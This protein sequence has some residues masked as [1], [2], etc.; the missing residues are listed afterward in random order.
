MSFPKEARIGLLVSITIV[1][2]FLGFFFLKGAD[3][4]SGENTYYSYFNNVQ[5]LQAS[6]PV[7]V[8]GLTVGRVSAINLD[9]N[10]RVRVTMRIG[11]ST[12]VPVGSIAKLSS[13]DLL[14]TKAIALVLGTGNSLVTDESVLPSAIEGGLVDAL[15]AQIT[16]LLVDVR[17]A[18]GTLDSLLVGVNGVLD[19]EA[20]QHLRASLASLNTTMDNF[21]RV[22]TRL[23]AESDELAGIIRNT[24]NI[25][26]NLAKNSDRID[27][28]IKNAELTS[29]QLAKAPIEQTLRD[30][31][32]AIG[33]L[34]GV[35]NKV[36]SNE[37][38][39]GML[40]ND[41]GLYN[42][43]TSSLGSLESL[44]ADIEAHPAR[45]INLTIFGRRRQ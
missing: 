42:N 31:E 25:T 17:H 10:G 2:L 19:I 33:Q 24:N 39:L 32:S 43:L 29:D 3:V 44:L 37:G 9:D 27:R 41:K 40:V 21:A 6:S 16:P 26:G 35:V 4:F 20:R 34:Q 28:I 13:T 38:S 1:V 23:N 12:E 36:N 8:K 30:L 11:K 18:V 7:Q 5:G 14:G 45:Y 22:S 15:S